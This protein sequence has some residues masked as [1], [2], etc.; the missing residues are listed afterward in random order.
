[1]HFQGSRLAWSVSTSATHSSRGAR[2][3]SEGPPA[4]RSVNATCRE[5][6]DHDTMFT[7][8]PGGMPWTDLGGGERGER[9]S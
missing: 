2:G 4:D 3:G 6:G 7:Q 1:M 9:G 5:S 8:H